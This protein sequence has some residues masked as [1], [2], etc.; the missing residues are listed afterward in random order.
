MISQQDRVDRTTQKAA[1]WLSVYCLNS[2]VQVIYC[3]MRALGSIPVYI[4]IFLLSVLILKTG[5]HASGLSNEFGHFLPLW[6]QAMSCEK[7]K[8]HTKCS[9]EF[10]YRKEYFIL[11]FLQMSVLCTKMIFSVLSEIYGW[12][13]ACCAWMQDCI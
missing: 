1:S 13:Q 6:F 8:H 11:F 5:A 2:R 4:C 12:S 7:I 9:S 3:F 10:W